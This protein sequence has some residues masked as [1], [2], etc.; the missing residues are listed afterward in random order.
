MDKV[1]RLGMGVAA[2][3]TVAT[4]DIR[5]VEYQRIPYGLEAEDWGANEGPCHDCGV[6][7][8]LLHV[9]GCDVELCPCCGGQAIYCECND[10]AEA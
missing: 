10:D 4:Y 5:G 9:V 2:S 6:H 8:G 7:K 3:Q 1:T